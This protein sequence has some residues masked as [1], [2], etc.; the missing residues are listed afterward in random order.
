MVKQKISLI[1]GSDNTTKTINTEY[2]N[3]CLKVI[4]GF[5]DGFNISFNDGYYKGV[6]E[7]SLIITIYTD[8]LKEDDLNLM[9]TKLKQELKQESI[10]KVI[11]KSNFC[12]I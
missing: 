3:K 5:Y 6:K 7:E 8:D 12:F 9:I 11:E 1:I 2:L 4:S 10:L